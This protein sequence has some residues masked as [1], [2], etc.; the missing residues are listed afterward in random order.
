MTA[1]PR[2]DRYVAFELGEPGHGREFATGLHAAVASWPKEDRPR[3]LFI[4]GRCG[5]V[6][7]D[8]FTKDAVVRLLNA[9]RLPGPTPSVQT[10]G[11]SGTIRRA[12]TKYFRKT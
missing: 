1:G 12:R 5:L 9:M 2:R 8:Q 6:R 4:E 7:C 10:L 3:L 11:T